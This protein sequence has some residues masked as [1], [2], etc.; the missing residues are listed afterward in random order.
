MKIGIDA[1]EPFKLLTTFISGAGSFFPVF[2]FFFFFLG[3]QSRP[4]DLFCFY[5][6]RINVKMICINVKKN[7]K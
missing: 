3:R 5:L 4:V 6:N 7:Y 2:V 1:F